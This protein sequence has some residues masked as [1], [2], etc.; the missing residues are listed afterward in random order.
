MSS[1]PPLFHC[2][3]APLSISTTGTSIPPLDRD[4]TS[5]CCETS[6]VGVGLWSTRYRAAKKE[7]KNIFE[8]SF[9]PQFPIRLPAFLYPTY[10]ARSTSQW[11]RS[12][13]IFN[14]LYFIYFLNISMVLHHSFLFNSFHK[15]II[16]S[17]CQY[18]SVLRGC[19]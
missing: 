14:S 5:R 19:Y 1:N 9:G 6:W 3:V 16:H 4:V 15:S 10:R 7:K 12:S 2:S 11:G 8:K 17:V 13:D 18:R